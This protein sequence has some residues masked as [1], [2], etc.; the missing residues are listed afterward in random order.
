[1]RLNEPV[2]KYGSDHGALDRIHMEATAAG[3]SMTGQST[4]PNLK[5]L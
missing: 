2:A 1:M 3:W 4:Q 5:L